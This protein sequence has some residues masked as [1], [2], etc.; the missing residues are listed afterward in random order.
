[1]KQLRI[2][3]VDVEHEPATMTIEVE[4]GGRRYVEDRDTAAVVGGSKEL[5]VTFTETW[6]FSLSG[7]ESNG[8]PGC[9]T[10]LPRPRRVMD[11]T[12]QLSNLSTDLQ[13]LLSRA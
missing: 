8:W 10:V 6:V 13:E 1:M 12:G 9:G 2:L 4:V 11:L 3:S 5:P 7:A